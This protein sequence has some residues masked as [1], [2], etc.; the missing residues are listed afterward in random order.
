MEDHHSGE[1]VSFVIECIDQRDPTSVL[2]QLENLRTPRK[3]KTMM[4]NDNEN[5]EYYDYLEI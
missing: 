5:C 2:I 1:V 4:K 3:Q